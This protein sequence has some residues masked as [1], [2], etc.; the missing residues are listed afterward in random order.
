VAGQIELR[1]APL[2]EERKPYV[3]AVLERAAEDIDFR[4]RLLADPEAAL[5]DTN[6]TEDERSALATMRRVALE[7]WGLDIRRQRAFLRD[8]GAKVT[9]DI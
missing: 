8:N 6:L 9:P 3:Q 5:A 1:L 4:E 2:A 7:E